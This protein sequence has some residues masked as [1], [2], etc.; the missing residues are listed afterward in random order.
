MIKHLKYST[1]SVPP[2]YEESFKKA[3]L[4]FKHQRVY[5]SKA[6]DIIHLSDISE[7][8]GEDSDFVGPYPFETSLL[9]LG[10][11]MFMKID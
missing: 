10:T 6:G 4:T 1:V 9:I 11:G 7:A 3:M 5:D 8:I 2:L